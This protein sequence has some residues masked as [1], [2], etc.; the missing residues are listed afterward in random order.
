MHPGG[1]NQDREVIKYLVSVGGPQLTELR[2]NTGAKAEDEWSDELKEYIA[3]TTN[4]LPALSDD[5]QCP[6]CFLS[7]IHISEP[8][9][10]Y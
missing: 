6:I 8:T 4:T 5:L 7:L 1:T 9:R 3:F 10:P 2:N